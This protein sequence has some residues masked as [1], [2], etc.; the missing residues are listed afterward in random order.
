MRK[1]GGN[2]KGSGRP[3]RKLWKVLLGLIAAGGLCFVLTFALVLSG[4]HDDIRGEPGV[5]VVLGCQVKPWGPSVL[6][7]DRLNTAFDYW[8]DHPETLIVVT[9]GQGPDEP[10]T[11]ARAM[12]DS[13]MEMGVPRESILL[14]EESSSTMENLRF[15]GQL[16]EER[17]Y[18]RSEGVVI[19]SNGFHLTRA[20]MLARR[21]GYGSVSAL[22]AP[23]SHTLSR[24]KMYVR[25]P[26]ALWK[27]FLLDR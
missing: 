23:S 27:S 3:G 26:L 25:E 17:G 14:E 2:R 24:L 22:A 18:D 19:V 5:M 8:E 13:L 11:E 15:A 12:A 16:L 9:G 20:K 21:A 6:L 10:S 4:C 7:Q 1:S